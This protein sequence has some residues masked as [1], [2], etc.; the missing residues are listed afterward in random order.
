MEWQ[1]NEH[2][3]RII[4]EPPKRT[5][6]ITG[7]RFSSVLDLNKYQTPFGAWCEIVGLVKLPFEDNKYTIA[8][9][10][11]EPKQIE[12]AKTKFPNIKSC[13]EYY[14]NSFPE[15]QYSNFKDLGRIFDGVRDFVSTKS[16]GITIVA[17]GECKTS[18]KPQDWANNMVPVDYLCQGM[19]YAYLDELD[20]ILYVA[21]FLQ[22]MDYNNPENYVVSEENTIFV[23]KKLKDCYIPLPHEDPD[24][25]DEIKGDWTTCDI[26][27]GGIQ[28]AI[29]YCEKWWEV[30]VETGISPEFD[31]VRDKEYLDIIRKSRPSND[32][33]LEDICSQAITLVKEIEL[34]KVSSGISGKEKELKI[35]EKCI[36]EK[37]IETELYSCNGYE[38]KESKKEKFNEKRFAEEQGKLYNKYLEE[39]VTYRLTKKVEEE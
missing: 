34:L 2:K 16:D 6:K 8:G 5:K 30:F 39:E 21:S 20:R 35:L 28:E 26:R 12:Y 9:K 24:N 36:K 15:Y 27:H 22:P 38:L 23:V 33:E 19:L 14:G 32:N 18:S 11:I 17:D 4:V 3:T 29:D 13:E 10:T 25:S 1:Y 7:H 31:E 37:M